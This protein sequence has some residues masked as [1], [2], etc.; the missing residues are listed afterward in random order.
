M[1][2][3]QYLEPVMRNIE[4]FLDDTQTSVTGEVEVELRPY[5][6]SV[7]GCSS[8]FDLMNSR[9]GEYGEQNKSLTSDDM[10]GFTKVLANPLKIYYTIH[11]EEN[12]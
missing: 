7:L 9:F 1:H 4:K 12:K 5:H 3:A 2:E 8:E 10:I 6:F 11:N